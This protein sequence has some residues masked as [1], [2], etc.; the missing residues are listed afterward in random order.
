MSYSKITSHLS[1]QRPLRGFNGPRPGRLMWSLI[2]TKSPSLYTGF[3]E[4][5]AFVAIKTSTPSLAKTRT[6]NVIYN[7]KNYTVS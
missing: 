6:G 5:H 2:M 1:S 7:I 4:P 3:I